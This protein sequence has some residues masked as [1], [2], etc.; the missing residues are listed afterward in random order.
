M[1]QEKASGQE[2]L[3]RYR[4]KY[5]TKSEKFRARVTKEQYKQ[6]LNATQR[7][8]YPDQFKNERVPPP[9]RF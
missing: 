2:I 4:G 1:S 9:K 6:Q 5:E 3:T 8:L 7:R